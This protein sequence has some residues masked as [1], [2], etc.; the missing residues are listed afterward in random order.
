MRYYNEVKTERKIR[1]K[2]TLFTFLIIFIVSSS[3]Y[4][5]TSSSGRQVLPDIIKEWMKEDK[6]EQVL[7]PK[8][9]RA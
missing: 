4:F 7:K 2:A 6:P 5:T 1:R 9:D 3:I 8:K